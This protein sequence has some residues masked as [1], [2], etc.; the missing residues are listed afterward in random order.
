MIVLASQT[1]EG[2]VYELVVAPLHPDALQVVTQFTTVPHVRIR[3]E[4]SDV[5][6]RDS[7]AG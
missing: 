5:S 1:V 2:L 7:Q 4:G 3:K 6:A